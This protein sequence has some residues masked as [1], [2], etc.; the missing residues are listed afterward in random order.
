MTGLP[1]LYCQTTDGFHELESQWNLFNG[2]NTSPH[3]PLMKKGFLFL[4]IT[5]I[6][7]PQAKQGSI[8]VDHH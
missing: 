6:K 3:W 5:L 8:A 1:E 4:N 7:D 2:S